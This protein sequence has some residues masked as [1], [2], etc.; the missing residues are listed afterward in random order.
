[1]KNFLIL[2]ILL[3]M[4]FSVKAQL[5]GVEKMVGTWRLD[6]MSDFDMDSEDSLEYE[7]LKSSMF[8]E[9][10]SDLRFSYSQIEEVDQVIS[11]KGDWSFSGEKLT[12]CF[13]MSPDDCAFQVVDLNEEVLKFIFFEENI[14]FRKE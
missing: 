8:I 13:D 3:V 7:M 2:T 11:V 4:S 1:M 10:C 6:S 9:F 5:S 14:F 12:M